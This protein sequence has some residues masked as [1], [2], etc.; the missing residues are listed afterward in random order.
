MSQRLRRI[1]KYLLQRMQE[2]STWR[3]IVLLLSVLGAQLKP[4]QVE[5]FILVGMALAGIIAVAFPDKRK[6]DDAE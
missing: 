5:A 6:R 3:G 4:E 1:W 2:A